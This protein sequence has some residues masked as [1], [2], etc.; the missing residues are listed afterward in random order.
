MGNVAP[1][2]W[3]SIVTTH[4]LGS[5]PA[6]SRETGPSPASAVVV[7]VCLEITFLRPT[8]LIPLS[9]DEPNSGCTV[10]AGVCAKG[11]G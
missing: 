11:L 10:T 8:P 9:D 6:S 2:S 3:P 4:S 1:T 5:S 7:V